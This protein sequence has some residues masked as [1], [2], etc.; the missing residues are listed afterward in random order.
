MYIY[1]YIFFLDSSIHMRFSYMSFLW[2]YSREKV[3]LN[4]AYKPS[5]KC[6]KTFKTINRYVG[7]RTLTVNPNES[8]MNMDS[9]ICL[10]RRK[11]TEKEKQEKSQLWFPLFSPETQDLF[12]H[13][14]STCE[15][16]K[17]TGYCTSISRYHIISCLWH[18]IVKNTSY[19]KQNKQYK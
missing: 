12:G 3:M 2:E 5:P 7:L 14:V 15:R 13:V 17:I 16:L 6:Y 9:W 11:G 10:H 18:N 1:I 4:R 8:G 19:E